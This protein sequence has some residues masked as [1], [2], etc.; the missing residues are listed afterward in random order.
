MGNCMST[1]SSEKEVMEEKHNATTA[2]LGSRQLELERAQN[3]LQQPRNNAPESDKEAKDL[4]RQLEVL[5]EEYGLKDK[6]LKSEYGVKEKNR[7]T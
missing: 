4:R 6:D 2:L 5:K 7:Q 3:D 1:S